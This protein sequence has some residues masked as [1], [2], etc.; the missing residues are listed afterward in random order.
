RGGAGRVRATRRGV[1]RDVGVGRPDERVERHRLVGKEHLGVVL[2]ATCG[3]IPLQ[4]RLLLD[5]EGRVQVNVVAVVVL[6]LER[7]VDGN[8]GLHAGKRR[9]AGLDVYERRPAGEAEH[10]PAAL[11]VLVDLV[12]GA[13]RAA[14]GAIP[15][16]GRGAVGLEDAAVELDDRLLA[17]VADARA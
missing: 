3:E 8:L 17:P 16:R 4:V 10:A 14:A 6:D 7:H 15:G 5:A 13:A 2:L 1:R 9:V 11:G 12:D